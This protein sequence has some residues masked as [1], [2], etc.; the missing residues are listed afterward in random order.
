VNVAVGDVN[1]DGRADIVTGAGAGG[2]PHVKV[3][4]ATGLDQTNA[5]GTIADTALLGNFMAF[6]LAFGGGVNVSAG[7]FNGDGLADVVVGAGAGGGP[8]VKVVSGTG[9]SRTNADGGIAADA[10][11][12]DLSAFEEE[13]RGGVRVGVADGLPGGGSGLILGAGPG[14]GP[15]VRVLRTDGLSVVED[16]FAAA[17]EFAGGVFV[18]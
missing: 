14:G 15:R 11:L 9:L 10:L 1:G 6:D 7:D 17:P 3:V 8:H 2:G 18:G 4:N 16:F 12:A 5:D 13:F